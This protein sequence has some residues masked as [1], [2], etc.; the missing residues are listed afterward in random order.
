[1]PITGYRLTCAENRASNQDP[2]IFS[3]DLRLISCAQRCLT[4]HDLRFPVYRWPLLGYRPPIAGSRS[5][6]KERDK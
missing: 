1:M 3:A 2:P 4:I 5:A 6:K